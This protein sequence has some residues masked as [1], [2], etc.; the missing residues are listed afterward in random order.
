MHHPERLGKYPITG[1]L[2]E[3]A[4]GVVYRAYDPD[5]RRMVALKTIRRQ[6]GESAEAV[7]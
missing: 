6:G 3:G 4:M 5:I 1:V 7:A 2:G